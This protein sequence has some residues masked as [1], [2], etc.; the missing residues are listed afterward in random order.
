M[1]VRCH[2]VVAAFLLGAHREMAELAALFAASL[3]AADDVR[4]GAEASLLAVCF[5][6]QHFCAT[7]L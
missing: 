5:T 3:S 7:R 1:V 2:V 6:R 4:S